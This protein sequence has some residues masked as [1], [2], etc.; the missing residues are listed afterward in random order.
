MKHKTGKPEPELSRPLRAEKI[1]ANGIEETIVANERERNALAMRF[2]LLDLSSLEARLN[3]VPARDKAGFAVDGILTAEVVQ[4]CVVTLE[5]LPASIRHAI[6]V[7]F[8]A[9]SVA[10]GISE[11]A[12]NEEDVEPVQDGVI[13]LGELVAQHLGIALDPYPRKPGLAPLEAEFGQPLAEVS[14]FAKLAELK[15]KPKE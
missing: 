11:R 8:A 13:D 7:H 12:L 3:V 1:P 6:R 10:S 2:G 15:K 5:P 4:R 9:G 14:P